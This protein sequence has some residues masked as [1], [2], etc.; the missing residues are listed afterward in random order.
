MHRASPQMK[1]RFAKGIC[2]VVWLLLI[3]GGAGRAEDI[4]QIRPTGY[5]TDL[6]GIIQPQTKSQLEALCTE[7][8]QKTGAQMAIVTVK[9]LDGN[10]IQTYASDLFKLL[11]IGQKKQDN[12]VMLLVAPN[13]RK[14]WTEVGYG[15]EPVINDARAGDAGRLLVPY[16]R[17]GD[18]SSGI[19]ATAWALAKYIADDKGVTLTGMPQLRSAPQGKDDDFSGIWVWLILGALVFFFLARHGGGGVTGFLIGSILGSMG[20][21][22]RGGWGG[23]GGGWGGSGGWGGGGGG[24]GGFGGGSSGG[25]GAG[26]SW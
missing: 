1:K 9:S 15:L 12:G 5:V 3:A 23:S 2:L 19:A 18:Y 13:E 4:K 20:G 16:F 26:G 21:G 10:D 6:A 24:F 11:G 25:G 8:E 17:Q 22:N 7:L 14:Y